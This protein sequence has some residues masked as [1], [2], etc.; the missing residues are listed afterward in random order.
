MVYL[1]FAVGDEGDE[2]DDVL[3]T[4]DIRPGRALSPMVN[5]CS[6]KYTVLPKFAYPSELI[7]RK[8]EMRD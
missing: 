6:V 2:G 1:N 7:T 4:C 3:V 8:L 5:P